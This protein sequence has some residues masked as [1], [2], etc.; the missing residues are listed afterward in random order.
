MGQMCSTTCTHIVDALF[1]RGA[2]RGR[3][4]EKVAREKVRLI[5]FINNEKEAIRV[6]LD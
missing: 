1:F 2:R 4:P 5:W 6:A 3:V